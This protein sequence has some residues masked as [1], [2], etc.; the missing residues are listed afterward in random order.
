M[1]LILG[2]IEQGLIFA[3]MAL[4]VYIT[5]HILDFP[6]LTVDGSFPLGGALTAA[7]L[8]AGISPFATLPL[9]FLAGAAAGALTGIIHVKLKVQNLV[10]GIIVMTGLYTINLRIAGKANVPLFSVDTIFSGSGVAG[11]LPNALAPYSALIIIAIMAGIV[12]LLL[13]L[14]M[15]TKSGY[16]LRAVGDNEQLVTT[17]A[18]D[19]GSVKILGLTIANG[20]VAL[21]GSIMVQWQGVFDITIGT[22]TVV[23]ALAS[24]IIGISLARVV[25]HLGASSAVCIGSVLYRS[26]VAIA[27]A[28]GLSATD[29][30][31]VTAVLLL[32][33]L[34]ATTQRRKRV[35]ARSLG[36][37]TGRDTVVAAPESGVSADA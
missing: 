4:G 32:V 35:K 36:D 9:S 18:K 13:D 3:I 29:L 23:I 21:S 1:T 26:A 28:Y 34:V 31:L 17:L 30:K 8:S 25:P 19:R 37:T 27:I 2:T 16:L 12:K 5:Y 7:L 22:G 6:D 33:I 10:A 24:V 11:L 20:L 15:G 14:Y